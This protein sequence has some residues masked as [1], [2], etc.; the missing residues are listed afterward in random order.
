[1][2]STA[3]KSARLVKRHALRTVERSAPR[4]AHQASVSSPPAGMSAPCAA[5]SSSANSPARRSLPMTA[6]VP[7]GRSTRMTSASPA[8]QPGGKK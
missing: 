1:M 4:A 3:S 8:S 5:R 2:R 7:P 6:S